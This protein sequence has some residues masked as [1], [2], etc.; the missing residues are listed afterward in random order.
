MS[1]PEAV[2]TRAEQEERE[3]RQAELERELHGA[4]PAEVGQKLE[5]SVAKL[6][7]WPRSPSGSELMADVAAD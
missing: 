2:V 5:A 4:Q 6:Q 7:A 1:G 3:L